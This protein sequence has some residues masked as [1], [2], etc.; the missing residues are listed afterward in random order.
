[1]P[2]VEMVCM[3]N[4][5]KHSNHCVAGLRTSGA[6]W[7]RP[8]S[9][10]AD[11]ALSAAQ[12]IL[13]GGERPKPLDVIRVPLREHRPREHQ[14]ENWVIEGSEWKYV[15][16]ADATIVPLLEEHLYDETFLF[17]DSSDRI[18]MSRFATTPALESLALIVPADLRWRI[19]T[20]YRGN[21]QTRAIFRHGD[22]HYNLGVTDLDWNEHL[23]EKGYKVGTS[24]TSS[25]ARDGRILL[26]VSL[27]EPTDWDGCC[28]KLVAAV[29]VI[30]E[31][32][33]ARFE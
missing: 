25:L 8:V 2:Y 3:A 33:D 24:R 29:I 16:R 13:D 21:R 6:G 32:W 14:P 1:M 26:T 4:S 15:D 19:T 9:D 10:T 12:C 23:E 18:H 11:G 27:S 22:G 7:V 20:S 5:E 17:G 30:P 31:K 28:Y